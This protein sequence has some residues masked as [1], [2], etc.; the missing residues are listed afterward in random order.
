MRRT[1]RR[2]YEQVPVSAGDVWII[3]HESSRRRDH[4]H[5]AEVRS[6]L[7]TDRAREF[8]FRCV[9]VHVQTIL[10]VPTTVVFQSGF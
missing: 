5:G 4:R 9:H 3:L 2:R 6:R 8:I 1:V 10:R 7:A